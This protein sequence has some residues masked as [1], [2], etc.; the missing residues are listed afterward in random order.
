MGLFQK[1]F[2]KQEPKPKGEY[3]ALTAY[4]PVFTDYN[5][6]LYEV[7]LVRAA[8]HA[9]ATVASKLK[10]EFR[11][12]GAQYL[13]KRLKKPNTFMTWSQFFYRL[14]TIYELDN[15]AFIVPV[16]DQFNRVTELYP[17][18][19]GRCKMVQVNN[20]PWLA[21][22]FREG[23]VAQLP[24]GQ[25]GVLT[26][27]QYRNDFFGETNQALDSTMKLIEVQ[28]QGIAEGVK[29][30]ATYRFMARYNN[31]SFD[32]DIT[33]EQTRFNDLAGRKGGIALL[34][35]KTY[36]DIKQ[37]D[38][39]P[40][41]IDAQQMKII[42]DNVFSYFGVNEDIIQN[43]AYGDKWTAFYE[44]DIEPWA[45]QLG[46]VLLNML[47]G[48]GELSGDAEVVL[49]ANRM[50]Y[51]ESKQRL[52]ISTELSDRGILNRDEVREIWNLPPLPNGEG[53]AYIIR[54]EY[55]NADEKINGGKA[56]KKPDDE[57]DP[58]DETD[59]EDGNDDA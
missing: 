40:F 36:E 8:V 53:Q 30:A 10:I 21:F 25:V 19:P 38:S 49:N 35:P 59:E 34:F 16:F 46:D 57:D 33:K 55:M 13:A 6:E 27:F 39:K 56:A 43:K 11:G 44:G 12:H 17:V 37:I 45:V 42:Q 32:E 24:V 54:G 23:S 7:E 4:S 14:K 20:Q 2:G 26:K 50:V 58:D 51:M 47:R 48:I 9:K 41:V 52:N 28:N 31:L 3:K 22:E 1:I 15:S 29:S 18:L 5:G